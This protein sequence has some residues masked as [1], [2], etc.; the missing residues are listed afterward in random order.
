MS[1]RTC[2]AKVV[3]SGKEI[4]AFNE[5]GLTV[6]LTRSQRQIFFKYKLPGF[7]D[8][9]FHEFQSREILS[10]DFTIERD[11]TIV[12]IRNVQKHAL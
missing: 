1:K 10:N 6:N 3:I 9:V 5:K 4:K 8:V 7:L 11:G 12:Y 2:I